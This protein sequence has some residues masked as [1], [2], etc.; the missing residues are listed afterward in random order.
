[1]KCE[2]T[3]SVPDSGFRAP[4]DPDPTQPGL[5]LLGSTGSIGR[6]TLEVAELLGLRVNALSADKNIGLL[7][8]Q[9]RRFQPSIAAVYDDAAARDFCVRVRDLDVRVIPGMDGLIEAATADGAGTA[10]IAVAGTAGLL[11]TLAAI[12]IGRRIALANKETLVCAGE[13][14]MNSAREYAADIIPVDSEHSAIFQC[15]HTEAQS[16]V[17]KIFSRHPAVLFAV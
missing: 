12:R 17:K 1:M 5:S 15:L 2:V 7:E 4:H 3:K 10:V 9:V 6:Q 13:F 14:V 11:P 8:E 16:C